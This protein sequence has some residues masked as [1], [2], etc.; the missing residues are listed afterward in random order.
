MEKEAEEDK[1]VSELLKLKD[2]VARLRAQMAQLQKEKKDLTQEERLRKQILQLQ[3]QLQK[4][5]QKTAQLERE[6]KSLEKVVDELRLLVKH[7]A[8][9]FTWGTS[10]SEFDCSPRRKIERRYFECI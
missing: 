6:K 3:E 2:E 5:K 1:R 7:C 9:S 4:Q 8:P 10:V